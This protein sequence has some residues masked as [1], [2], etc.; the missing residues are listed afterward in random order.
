[1]KIITFHSENAPENRSWV[2]YWLVP[3][4][5][6]P[7][8]VWKDKEGIMQYSFF[9]STEQEVIDKAQTGWDTSF[10]KSEKLKRDLAAAVSTVRKRTRG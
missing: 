8:K 3:M 2:A 1:M 10:G 7:D 9:G 5:E 4:K 6:V